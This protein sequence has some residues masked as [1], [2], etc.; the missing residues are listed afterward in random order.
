MIGWFLTSRIGQALV[1]AVAL[2]VAIMTFGAVSRGRGRRDAENDGLRDSAER[3]ERGRDAVQDLR[4][5][6][7]DDLVD[8]LRD[9]D[10]DW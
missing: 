6:D 9:N 2:I 7:R 1:G 8:Q 4:D 5:A 3:Q 10:G